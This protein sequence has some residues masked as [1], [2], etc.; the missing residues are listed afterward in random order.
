MSTGHREDTLDRAWRLDADDPVGA[1]LSIPP[2][3][4]VG[5][6]HA[7][8]NP[9]TYALATIVEEHTGQPCWPT[10]G[11]GSSTRSVSARARWDIDKHG[12]ALGFTGL[13]LQTE[14][15]ARFGQ[16]LL[17]DGQWNG[18]RILPEG[19][20]A[21]PPGSTSTTTTT[22]TAR[23]DWRQGYGYQYWMARHGF[24][25]DGAHGQFCVVVPDADLV[26]AT[27][28]RVDDMQHV[29]DVLWERLLPA[30]DADPGG[31]DRSASEARLTERLEASPSPCVVA[32]HEGPTGTDPFRRR[33]DEPRISRCPAAPSSP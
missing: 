10:Y 13:H 2:E 23:V 5:S 1:F 6:R 7:Y 28:A 3:E 29:L 22:R 24:R 27:T 20:V 33:R 32:A 16:L 8:N 9:T 4:P 31:A 15:I 25:G 14:S 12:V 30:L 21:W 17:Q 26:V 11:R 18:Q 19:W